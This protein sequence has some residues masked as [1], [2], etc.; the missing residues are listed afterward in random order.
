MFQTNAV[1]KSKHTF[2]VQYILFS[3]IVPFMR[4]CRKLLT[5]RTAH[6][7]QNGACALH[8]GYLRL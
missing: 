4:Q 2:C 1:E 6:R 5:S 7:R 8:A 3:E